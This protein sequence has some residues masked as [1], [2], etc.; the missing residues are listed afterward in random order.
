VVAGT[1]AALIATGGLASAAAPTADDPPPALTLDTP[2]IQAGGTVTHTVKMNAYQAGGLYVYMQ[3]GEGFRNWDLVNE[4]SDLTI[5]KID[6]GT[7]D[8]CFLRTSPNHVRT[9]LCDLEAGESIT[10]TYSLSAKADMEAWGIET[11]AKFQPLAQPEE[12]AETSNFSVLSDDPVEMSYRVFGRDTAGWLRS[13]ETFT[14][15]ILPLLPGDRDSHGTGWNAYDAITKLSPIGVD[16]RGGGIVAREP[17]G[18]LW[19]HP[20]TGRKWNTTFKYDRVR[21]GTGWD[22]YNSIRGTGDVTGDGR[23][24]LIARDKA[25][26]L[27]FYRGTRDESKPFAARVRVGSGWNV[28]NAMTGGIDVTKGGVADLYARDTSGA[29]WLYQGTG[30]AAKP[31]APRV[32]V[33]TGWNIYT[34]LIAPGDGTDIG[35]GALLA[36]D[37]TGKLWW[38]R[39]TGDAASPLVSRTPAAAT[40]QPYNAWL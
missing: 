11:N 30:D 12:T 1:A 38:Y 2:D 13:H 16:N 21:V 5:D 24:D 26:V 19:Y 8:T 6:G 37:K 29:L 34:A 25:G 20:T 33:G 27:W 14:V 9:I 23:A 35:K 4:A 15:S 17:S 36:R 31:Y 10:L 18:L 22:A 39:G 3:A 7:N 40:S 32:K 28:Y